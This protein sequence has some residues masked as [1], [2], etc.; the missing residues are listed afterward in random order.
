MTPPAPTGFDAFRAEAVGRMFARTRWLVLLVLEPT[1]AG[2][3]VYVAWTAVEIWRRD[4]AIGELVSIVL[5]N[6]L[7]L[8]KP[9]RFGVPARWALGIGIIAIS[10]GP[11]SPLLPVL[12]ISALSLP[13]ML[14][15]RPALVL[16]GLSIVSLWTMTLL[17]AHGSAA[18]YASAAC[19]T[20]LLAGAY[21]VGTWIRETS[22]HMLRAS[23][24]ARDEA[25]RSHCARLR[26]LT[27][28][29]EALAH[30]LKNPLASIKGLAGLVELD[31]ERACE[32]LAVLQKEVCR[33][34][35]ILDDHLSFSRPLTPMAA[36]VTDVRAVVGGVVRL[37]EG[38]ARQKELTL[39]MSRT[40]PLDVVGD[41]HKL[42]QML[43]HLVLNAIDASERG[44]TI[45]VTAVRDGERVR[46]AVL[47]RGPG[48]DAHMLSRAVEPGV[49][50]KE[51]ASGLGLTIVRALA[52]QHGGTLKLRNRDGGGLAAEVELPL[53]DAVARS[54]DR[55]SKFLTGRS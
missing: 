42:T 36:E 31:P 16:V 28:L 24:E 34:Q 19:M 1:L 53:G 13:A 3:C 41:P 9:I 25:V 39:D 45:E 52:G 35:H 5:I 10:G 23:L 4:A 38:M 30:E 50:T 27:T 15:R 22:D 6:L 17:Q 40:G 11:L 26:E 44:G 2:M 43:M 8:G 54:N 51:H 21:T 12:L 55:P 7:L 37:H 48:L 18:A 33:M 47:D 46:L 49:T 20:A 32:R 29:Q 14:G